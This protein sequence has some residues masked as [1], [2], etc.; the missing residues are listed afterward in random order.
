MVVVAVWH[1]TRRRKVV[2]IGIVVA[3]GIGIV[4]TIGI[5]V[6][7]RGLM[8]VSPKTLPDDKIS[9]SRDS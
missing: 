2:D 8:S 4:V 3:I 9:P 5:V 1:R 6:D 7:I